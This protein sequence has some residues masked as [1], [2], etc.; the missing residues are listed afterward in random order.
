MQSKAIPSVLSTIVGPSLESIHSKFLTLTPKVLTS[1][2]SSR[3]RS[4]YRYRPF[5]SQCLV[6][7]VYI[8]VL[9]EVDLVLGDRAGIVGIVKPAQI[10][11]SR[12]NR[13]IRFS[14]RGSENQSHPRL[15]ICSPEVVHPHSSPLLRYPSGNAP[16]ISTH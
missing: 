14:S 7:I 16:K 12:D 8:L 10:L 15:P 6:R 2:R 11:F 9:G 1:E 5:C 4:Q 13:V 3:T